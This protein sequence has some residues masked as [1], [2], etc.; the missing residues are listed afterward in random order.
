MINSA[1]KTIKWAL[2]AACI[3]LSTSFLA[4]PAAL[5]AGDSS[6]ASRSAKKADA[7]TSSTD[8][9]LPAGSPAPY[10]AIPTV[11]QVEWQRMEYYAFIHFGLNTFTGREWGYGDEEASAF[12]PKN[13][14]ADEIVKTLKAGG[15]KGMIYTAKHH[16]GWCAWPTKSTTHNITKSKWKDGKGDVVREFADACKKNDMKFGIYVSPW[17]R[18]HAEYAKPGYTAAYHKQIE[19]LFT[20]YGD[21]FELWLDGANGGDGYYGGARETRKLSQNAGKYYDFPGIVKMARELQPNASVWGVG[22]AGDVRWGGSEAGVVGYPHWPTIGGKEEHPASCKEGCKWVTAA[23]G[24]EDGKF[25]VPAE[26][27]TC[28]NRAGW[29]W[30]KQNNPKSAKE[31][32][33]I[34]FKSVGRGANLI[35]NLGPNQDGKLDSGD[36]KALMGFKNLRD[37]LYSKDFALGG[38]AVSK[39]SRGKKFS[40]QNLVDGD[41]DTFWTGKDDE[42]TAEAV[43]TL[44]A[45]STFDVVRLREE[46]RLGQRVKAWAIDA[47]VNGAWKEVLVGS[48]VG[49]QAMLRLD[50]PVTTQEVRLRIT[51]SAAVPCISELSLLKFPQ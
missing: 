13:F 30:H 29:F 37:R 25:W 44:P 45:P 47:K 34:W 31:L 32:L 5:G 51:K 20:N 38:K 28:I 8:H 27:D 39:T 42:L 23:H 14:N 12:N 1:S 17:D 40:A 11:R 36:V 2:C 4:V 19:E 49:N 41:I 21:L 15:M 50:A 18:N 6:K 24:I 9:K 10:G 26:A 48:S 46:I 16:D 33:D 3:A 7:V 22:N 43:I 35:L